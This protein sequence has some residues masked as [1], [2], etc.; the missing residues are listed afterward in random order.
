MEST[1]VIFALHPISSAARSILHDPRNHL[2]TQDISLGDNEPP[3]KSLVFSL[4]RTPKTGTSYVIG[5]NR[6]SDILLTDPESSGLHCLITT[7]TKG[8]PRLH[9]QSTNGTYVNEVCRNNEI[10]EIH[11]GMRI[12]IRKALFDVWVP[13]RGQAQQKYEYNARRAREKRANTPI[14]FLSCPVPDAKRT[15]TV[16]T[17]GQY[18]LTYVTLSVRWRTRLEIVRRKRSFFVAK[19]FIG[20]EDDSRESKAWERMSTLDVSHVK[21]PLR[22]F[23]VVI[24]SPL[25]PTIV[26]GGIDF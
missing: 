20:P 10:I 13:W 22:L 16:K 1:T 5:R 26:C 2:M 12:G 24:S 23:W 15:V 18:E 17:V 19:S 4:N 6:T 21:S 7:D 11:H 3:Q 9:E 25:I 14:D 8:V